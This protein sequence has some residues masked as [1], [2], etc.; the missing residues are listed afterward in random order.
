M[1]DK[2]IFVSDDH[3]L[4]NHVSGLLAKVLQYHDVDGLHDMVLHELC[5]DKVFGI[6]KATYLVDNPD[7]DHLLGVSGFCQKD[8]CHHKHDL[9][10]TPHT[11]SKDMSKAQFHNDVKKF[12]KNSLKRKDIDLNSSS[13]IKELGVGL[14]IEKPEFFTWNMKHGNHGILIFEKGEKPI[15]DWRISMLSNISALLG[16]CGI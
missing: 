8:C 1:N 11:F 15:C 7:F 12:L 14:G 4:A 13:D 3:K 6:K 10:E 9:W 16:F 2:N 5:H